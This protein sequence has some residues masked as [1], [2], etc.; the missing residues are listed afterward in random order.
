MTVPQYSIKEL[1]TLPEKLTLS[2][3]YDRVKEMAEH[4]IFTEMT[5]M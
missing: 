5:K 4:K 2:I 1:K 3:T